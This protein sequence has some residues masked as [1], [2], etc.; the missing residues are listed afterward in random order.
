MRRNAQAQ[1]PPMIHATATPARLIAARLLPLALLAPL[2]AQDAAPSIDAVP[3]LA[4]LGARWQAALVTLDVPGFSIAVVK[5]GKV[6]A[7]G[8]WGVR[9]AAGNPATPDTCYY[10]ASATKPFTAMGVCL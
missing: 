3:A 1:E 5:D 6:L 2:H 4:G 9:D 7:L 8:A 10:I